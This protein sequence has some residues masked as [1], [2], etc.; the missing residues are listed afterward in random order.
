VLA[1]AADIAIFKISA[2][3]R[4]IYK[5]VDYHLPAEDMFKGCEKLG[6]A[7]CGYVIRLS[8]RSSRKTQELVRVLLRREISQRLNAKFILLFDGS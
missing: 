1:E 5:L 7:R 4:Q 6:I 3:I 8:A 2:H